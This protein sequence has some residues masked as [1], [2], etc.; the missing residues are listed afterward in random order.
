V[1]LVGKINQWEG[2]FTPNGRYCPDLLDI[3]FACKQL[4][5]FVVIFCR[6]RLIYVLRK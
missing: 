4:T 5:V 3:A 2:G 6:L 1:A